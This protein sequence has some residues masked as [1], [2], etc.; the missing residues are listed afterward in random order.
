MKRAWFAILMLIQFQLAAQNVHVSIQQVPL[1]G[2]VVLKDVEDKYSAQVFNL[3]SPGPDAS[4][5]RKKLYAA[6]AI[7]AAMFPYK[8]TKAQYKTTSVSAPIV[9]QS[10]TADSL[11]GIPPDNDFAVSRANKGISVMNSRLAIIDATTGSMPSRKNLQTFCAPTG[12]NTTND[13]K[14]DPKVM[15]DPQAD[16]F[17]CVIL[18]S[19]NEFN[20]IVVGFSQ[21]NDPAGQWNFYKFYGDYKADSTW[22]DYP[23]VAITKDEFFL[24][25]NKIKYNGSWQAGFTESVIYQMNK[26]DGYSGAATLTTKTWDGIN[27]SSVFI[28]NL[29]PV[30]GGDG[31]AQYFLSNRN[32]DVQ[33]D[34]IFLVKVPNV[35]SSGNNNLEIKV[36][37][38][39][40]KYGVPPEGRQPDTSV[41]LATNDGRI[42]G[43]FCDG[44]EIQFVSASVAPVSGASGVFHGKITNYQ[45][46]PVLSHAAII[47]VDSLDFGYP[48]ISYMGNPWGLRQSIISFNYTGPNT[49]PGMGAI[50]FNGSEYSSIAN[51]KTGNG[52]IKQLT[53]KTQRW[54]DYMASQVDVSKPT[55]PIQGNSDKWRITAAVWIEGIFGRA[56]GRYGNWIAKINSPLLGIETEEKQSSVKIYPNPAIDLVE[57]EFDMNETETVSFKIHDIWGRTVD[58]ILNA[59]CKHGHNALQFNVAPLAA[60]NYI[61][62]ATTATGEEV[63]RKQFVKQ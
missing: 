47:T 4:V 25:G 40:I 35:I 45:T 38:S 44:D 1:A 26:N 24:T 42:L 10:F 53:G 50:L 49:Y 37:K 22:F 30:K 5:E 31:P 34:T 11:S 12:L 29:Y 23:C 51:V 59:K 32:F 36:L 58:Q 13:Y 19:T 14:Y 57:F 48:N 16:K 9:T 7:S 8:K 20:Y 27:G 41:T 15:Y 21:T 56:D 33:N 63:I 17:I 39:P 43:A 62:T 2:T 54:G 18:N 46:S 52:S 3:E 61:L 6:K 55:N 60:G 28:R